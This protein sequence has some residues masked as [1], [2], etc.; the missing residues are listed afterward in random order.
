VGDIDLVW[1]KEG[2]PGQPDDDGYGLARIIAKHGREMDVEKLQELLDDMRRVPSRWPDRAELESD[3]YHATV[4]LSWDHKAKKWLLTAFDRTIPASEKPRPAGETSSTASTPEERGEAHSPE[5]D[6]NTSVTPSAS[7]VKG[8]EPLNALRGTAT[9][10]AGTIGPRAV[11]KHGV[12]FANP[13]A[14]RLLQQIDKRNVNWEASAIHAPKVFNLRAGC[15]RG[16][17]GTFPA[18]TLSA[19]R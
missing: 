10:S 18:C 1:G 5:R 4:R 15:A 11:H 8:D 6:L 2:H 16:A 14:V 19:G 3:K 9:A 7:P 13:A 12:V 17:T